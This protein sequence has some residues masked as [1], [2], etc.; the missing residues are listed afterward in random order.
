[1]LLAGGRPDQ[2]CSNYPL[3]VSLSRKYR[4]RQEAACGFYPA[5]FEADESG[6]IAAKSWEWK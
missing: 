1:M 2:A 5:Q 4:K 3:A 6:K